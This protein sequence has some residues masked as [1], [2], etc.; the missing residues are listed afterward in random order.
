VASTDTPNDHP[1]RHAVDELLAAATACGVRVEQAA[2]KAG[3]SERTARRRTKEETFRQR[4]A[5]LRREMIDRALGQAS[6]AMLD[7]VIELR[8]LCRKG[9]S[10]AIRLSAANSLLDRGIALR[11]H[12]DYE[13]RLT[14]LEAKAAEKATRGKK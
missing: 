9:K 4:I 6:E 8:L 11:Q 3:I 10:E 14:A 2:E 7:A 1:G 13:E 5:E 12:V